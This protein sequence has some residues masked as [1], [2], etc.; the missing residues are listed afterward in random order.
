[1]TVVCGDLTGLFNL[2]VLPQYRRRGLGQ[3][4]TRELVRAGFAAGA[5]R[6]PVRERDGRVGLRGG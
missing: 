6:V 2:T 4:I 5:R 3:A 1:M